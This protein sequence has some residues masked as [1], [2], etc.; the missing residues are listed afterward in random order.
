LVIGEFKEEEAA[1]ELVN[2]ANSILQ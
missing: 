1:Q 2:K